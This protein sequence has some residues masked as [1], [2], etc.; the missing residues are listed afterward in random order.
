MRNW[1]PSPAELGYLLLSMG[2]FA[3]IIILG[4]SYENS[5]TVLHSFSGGPRQSHGLTMETGVYCA[6]GIVQLR[7][8]C[9]GM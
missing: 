8:S 2:A 1:N 3:L 6:E 4:F 9:L 5:Y 7:L